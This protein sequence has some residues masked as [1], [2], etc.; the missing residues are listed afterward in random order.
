MTLQRRIYE[1]RIQNL[2]EESK[3]GAGNASASNLAM[4]GGVASLGGDSSPVTTG[5]QPGGKGNRLLTPT[6]QYWNSEK[7]EFEKRDDLVSWEVMSKADSISSHS[8]AISHIF[9]KDDPVQSGPLISKMI[10]NH[11]SE[12]TKLRDM[13]GKDKA[14]NILRVHDKDSIFSGSNA[15][16]MIAKAP[17]YRKAIDESGIG[18]SVSDKGVPSVTDRSQLK[19]FSDKMNALVK[20]N[21]NKR[22]ASGGEKRGLKGD[23]N[24][25]NATAS[26]GRWWRVTRPVIMPGWEDTPGLP[27]GDGF[28][29]WE[30]LWTA[31]EIW[32]ALQKEMPKPPPPGGGD[33]GVNSDGWLTYWPPEGGPGF[34][35][36]MPEIN[37]DIIPDLLFWTVLVVIVVIVVVAAPGSIPILVAAEMPKGKPE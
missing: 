31:Y 23:E 11:A 8:S 5:M 13:V 3:A 21:N 2:P 33:I 12:I 20:E 36:S 6:V 34:E 15:L 32:H 28:F 4:S 22:K 30:D 14:D 27:D 9:A 35:I 7:G 24:N 16:D 26:L 29:G 18:I 25:D 37:P 19:E 10:I 1:S 17:K